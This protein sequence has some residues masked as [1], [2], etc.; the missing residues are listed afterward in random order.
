[1][2]T[3]IAERQVWRPVSALTF[4]RQIGAH[5]L[6]DGAVLV[7]ASR[8]ENGHTEPLQELIDRFDWVLVLAGSD[9]ESTLDTPA[10][11][12]PRMVV[13][14]QYPRPA[15]H[16]QH[17]PFPLGWPPDCPNL[18][19]RYHVEAE[20][21]PSDW[22]FA[23]Q[24]THDRRRDMVDALDGVPGGELHGS[25][26][27]AGGIQYPDYLRLMASAKLAPAPSGP[28]HPDSFRT[29]EALEAGTLPLV[30]AQA[31]HG[32][33]GLDGYWSWLCDGDPPF[34]VIDDWATLPTVIATELDRWPANAIRASG[35]WQGAKRD[36]AYR[37]DDTVRDLAGIEAKPMG[38]SDLV[39]VLIPTSPIPSHP[40]LKI[41]TE[42]IES[43]RAHPALTDAE[44]LVLCD[45]VRSAQEERRAQ[46]EHYLR[47]L[48]WTAEHE[49]ANVL[50]VVHGDHQHQARM[51]RHA[52]D[53][54]RTPLLLFVEHDC[55]I[56][57]DI[58]WGPLCA[59][60]MSGGANLV[61]FHHEAEVLDCHRYLM[62]HDG[63]RVDIEG[64][65]LLRCAQFSARPHLA[66]VDY[67]R[68]ILTDHFGV[69]ERTM[70]ED[71]MHGV[72]AS[73]WLDDGDAGWERHRLFMYAPT[74]GW[75]RRSRHLD[76]RAGDHKWVDG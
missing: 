37:L 25:D 41:I 62:P 54:V 32:V 8:M 2:I 61:R 60:L 24:V 40:D 34:P 18:L 74:D 23:G 49:W 42:T 9:E 22:V 26:V 67:Y 63:Q 66:R 46:Y 47:R 30:D 28:V 44:I 59:A 33:G 31:P 1:M 29:W 75:L 48:L 14:Q 11:H 45:G 12:H 7:V 3:G 65:P 36:W 56:D 68:R 35:W 53:L 55:P 71:R 27:F 21:R 5:P 76:G 19:P 17:R 51:T 39:T 72:V 57:D 15:L 70:V 4:D 64:A 69:D 6:P 50:P 20:A 16:G 58:A 38:V 10:L 52:L 73:A 43:I 13:W